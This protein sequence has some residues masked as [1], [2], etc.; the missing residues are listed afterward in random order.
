MP[1]ST[2]MPVV[3]SSTVR[4]RSMRVSGRAGMRVRFDGSTGSSAFAAQTAMSRP[5]TPP[6]TPSSTLSVSS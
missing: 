5:A 3:N 2:E 1:L 4:S 6:A